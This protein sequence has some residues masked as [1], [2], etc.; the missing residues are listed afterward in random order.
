MEG[1]R[2]KDHPAT[3]NARERYEALGIDKPLPAADQR[4]IYLDNDL[5][6]FVTVGENSCVNLICHF[7]DTTKQQVLDAVASVMGESYERVSMVPNVDL[8]E[9]LIDDDSE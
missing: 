9:E 8:E 1:L 2:V 3:I 6:G 5:V 4:A 7:D